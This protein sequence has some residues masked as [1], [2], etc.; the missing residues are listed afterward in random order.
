MTKEMQTLAIAPLGNLESYVR[1]ANNWPVLTAE[2]EKA[3]AQLRR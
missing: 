1:A 3:L 2:Q